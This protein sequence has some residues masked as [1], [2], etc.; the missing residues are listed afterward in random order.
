MKKRI[1]S[2][3]CAAAV[4][5]FPSGC[6]GGSVY[7]NYRDIGQLLVIQTMGFDE[8]DGEIVLSV[9]AEG[10]EGDGAGAD[11]SSNEPVRLHSSAQ[12]VADAREL[13][14]SYSGG[15]Q[16]FFGHT[17][18]VILGS[19][20]LSSGVGR[21]FD[22]IERDAS[23]R[24]CIPVFAVYSSSAA[25]LVLGSGGS[26]HD[27]TK[28]LRAATEDLRLRGDARVY[29]ASEIIS[30]LDRNGTALICAARTVPAGISDTAAEDGEMAILP[31]GYVVIH[32][33]KVV[34]KLPHELAAGVSLLKNEL[35]TMPIAVGGASLQID[36]A[37][38]TL[39]P[40]FGSDGKPE[41]LNISIE[42]S[43]SLAEAGKDSASQDEL[44][45]L[46]AQELKVRTEAV[47][48]YEAQCGCDFLHLGSALELRYPKK[49]SGCTGDF[50]RLLPFIY[51]NVRVNAR[52]DRS[53]HLGL[54][55]D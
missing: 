49:L 12:T 20:V 6:S 48:D 53:F 14:Q 33:G 34:G 26:R 11:V 2:L 51:Y 52:L 19:S 7:S 10:S 15:R 47:L 44:E 41:G 43:A 5:V 13:L 50:S 24:L 39:T 8:R 23:F 22:C 29:T 16:L 30:Q 25:E 45:K 21:Y 38:C 37:H 35:G 9:S 55:E 28:L 27:S 42:C 31:D 54:T 18:Y 46:L 32:D 4:F 36:R 1:L 17:S 3:L 40:V